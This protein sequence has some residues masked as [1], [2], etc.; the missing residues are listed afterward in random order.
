M[1]LN[2][3]TLDKTPEFDNWLPVRN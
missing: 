1:N 2:F 3:K